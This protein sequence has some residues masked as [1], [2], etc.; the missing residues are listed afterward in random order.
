MDALFQYAFQ[1]NPA[2][3]TLIYIYRTDS[4]V[5]AL[6]DN[7]VQETMQTYPGRVIRDCVQEESLLS[8]KS[9]YQ[10]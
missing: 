5:L 3:W 9:F 6:I 1:E 2:L 8:P 10:F 7:A 4:E